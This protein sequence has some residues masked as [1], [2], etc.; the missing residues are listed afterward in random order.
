MDVCFWKLSN[1]QWCHIIIN[2]RDN[3][4]DI[5]LQL[6]T[7]LDVLDE[8]SCVQLLKRSN[9]NKPSKATWPNIIIDPS[10]SK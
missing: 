10:L 8:S 5:D 9:L 4:F 2:M 6:V 7:S 3:D 1:G